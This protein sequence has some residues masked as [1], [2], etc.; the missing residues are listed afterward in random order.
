MGL[1][2]PMGTQTIISQND[3]LINIL[4]FVENTDPILEERDANSSE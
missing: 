4:K 2:S 1:S 3:S